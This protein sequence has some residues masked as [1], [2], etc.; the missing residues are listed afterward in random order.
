[1]NETT[2]KWCGQ[3]P[4]ACGVG[5]AVDL[6]I[7]LTPLDPFSDVPDADRSTTQP[8]TRRVH[9]PFELLKASMAIVD[10]GEAHEAT[11][12]VTLAPIGDNN[13]DSFL[14]PDPFAATDQFSMDALVLGDPTNIVESVRLRMRNLDIDLDDLEDSD[15]GAPERTFEKQLFIGADVE[16]LLTPLIVLERRP[17]A[18]DM[19]VLS[20]FE[21]F[22]LEQIDGS[23]TIHDI[24]Y[25]MGLSEGDLRIAVALLADKHLVQLAQGFVQKSPPQQQQPASTPAT[26]TKASS[27]SDIPAFVPLPVIVSPPMALAP[28][29]ELA[30]VAPVTL[31]PLPAA[32]PK[33]STQQ[34]Q[35]LTALGLI[36]ARA[37]RAEDENDLVVALSLL[38][39]AIRLE[40][41]SAIAHNRL[42]VLL[43]RT[44]DLPGALQMLTRALELRPDDPTIQSNYNK[45]AS[46]ADRQHA[47]KKKPIKRR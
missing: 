39:E 35:Q 18:A 45:I 29:P 21:R 5:P 1:M 10:R 44:R 11:Q 8:P 24:Q 41:A 38:R 25:A 31:R 3:K 16:R 46:L 37:A 42:G 33:T 23:R 15:E 6:D 27:T 19:S 12:P 20:P 34:Q 7:G 28:V 22:V 30:D 17:T 2:C 26:A 43:A 9:A 36:M 40:P 14:G 32:L 47:D 4:C 13:S